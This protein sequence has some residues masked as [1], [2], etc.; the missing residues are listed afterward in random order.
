MTWIAW[1]TENWF[2]L[3]QSIGII[4][5]LFYT[6]FQ[7]HLDI[8]TRRMEA[9]F[10]ITKHHR[11]LW[12]SFADKP[13][14]ARVLDPNADLEE[15]PVTVAEREFVLQV[16]LHLNAVFTA[17]HEGIAPLSSG[18]NADLREFF[19]NPIPL[20]VWKEGRA[21][22]DPNLRRFVEKIINH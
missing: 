18:L 9:R 17:Q 3:L 12:G 6:G 2:T 8:R 1:T 16:I 11:E 21:K 20:S 13:N 15:A 14:L 5:G 7:I 22:R 19:Q 4:G 10:T